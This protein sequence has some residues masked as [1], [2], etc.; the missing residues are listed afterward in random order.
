M[1]ASVSRRQF[2]S[3]VAVAG[4]ALSAPAVLAA[5]GGGGAPSIAS[6]CDG[7]A[8]LSP[9]EI[10]VRQNLNYVDVTPNTAQNCANCIQYIP[11]ASESPCAG[12]KLFAGPVLANGYCS[13]WAAMPAS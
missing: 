6:A 7:Y 5:C 13:V 11:P 4:A 2:L 3:R 1:P 10:Q 12:C 8:D 9:E